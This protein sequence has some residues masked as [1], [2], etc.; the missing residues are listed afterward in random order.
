[1][2]T[3]RNSTSALGGNVIV[4]LGVAFLL[5]FAKELL[6]PLAFS[7]VLTL[8]LLP[9]VSWLQSK[10]LSRSLAVV[11][12]GALT[13][14]IL[15][16]GAYVLV[17]QVLS[18]AQTLPGYRANI[19]RR[20]ES[21]NSSAAGSIKVAATMLEEVSGRLGG[22]PA[23]PNAV[24]VQLVTPESD[25]LVATEEMVTT[26]LKPLGEI[27]VIL[28][29]AIYMLMNWDELRHRLLLLVGMG[30]INLMTRALDE[31][32][33]RISR[34]L[35]LQFQFNACYGLLFGSGLFLLGIPN[36]TLWG[37]IAG[38]LRIVPFVGTMIG[39][40][41]PLM[42]SVAVSSSWVT[43]ICVVGLFLVLELTA[44]N[45]VEPWL[46]SSRTG[47]SSLALLASAI[48]WSMLWGWP[49]LVLATPLTVCLVVLGRHVPHLSF[50]HS[51]LGTNAKLSPAA[52]LYER[53]LAMDDAE[54]WAI[55]EEYLKTA[56]LL[57]LYE[58][59]VF[60]VLG[61]AEEDRHKGA[62][63][64]HQWTFIRLWM[65]ELV[66]RLNSFQETAEA[67]D[68]STRPL[69][70]YATQARKE[71]ATICLS[72]G[73]HATE[74]STQMLAQLLERAGHQT[75][76][77]RADALSDEVLAALGT[78][79]DTI[80]FISALPPFAFAQT[81][82][83]CQRVRVH[84]PANRVAV[85]IWNSN[86]EGDEAVERFG[87]A[88]PNVVLNNLSQAVRQVGIWQQERR[89]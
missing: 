9:L 74:L 87:G 26:V 27:G 81:R 85:A 73:D 70:L 20:V 62:L 10:K 17:R 18:V 52:H 13:C 41:L 86:E 29:F 69:A 34:Y 4:F 36:A 80:L 71:V 21:L 25:R 64:R 89:T 51:L 6:I 7:L 72:A 75:L 48:F 50:L 84:L 24:S 68:S 46:F 5:F 57:K 14:V 55:V 39:M 58:S 30:N 15:A 65:G 33:S 45:F 38:V 66:A 82:T 42:L 12:A 61:L 11:V 83:L 44:A 19:E 2:S 59:V 23:H 49:G 8:L 16:G 28:V 77:L 78:E 56:T 47:I 88:R 31:A 43:P 37:V 67:A 60:C 35:V 1:M 22:S 3:P 40:L 76:V 79:A 32:T 63:D 53:L 54:A